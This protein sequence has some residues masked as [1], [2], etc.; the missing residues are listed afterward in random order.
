M[1]VF[2]VSYMHGRKNVWAQAW[3]LLNI[4]GNSSRYLYRLWQWIVSSH[5]LNSFCLW[6]DLGCVVSFV[7]ISFHILYVICRTI[8]SFLSPW[9]DQDFF[10]FPASSWSSC[11]KRCPGTKTKKEKS[12]YFQPINMRWR[13]FT[14]CH[15]ALNKPSW[16]IC[17]PQESGMSSTLFPHCEE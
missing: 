8:M 15:L 16:W 2:Y 7:L 4:K 13:K 3:K 9:I 10:V 14:S 11:F 6:E 12:Y 1:E 5:C 17:M